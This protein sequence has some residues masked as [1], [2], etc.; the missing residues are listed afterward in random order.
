M[1]QSKRRARKSGRLSKALRADLSQ[2][3]LAAAAAGMG[4]L[5]ASNPAQAQIVFTPANQEIGP[6]QKLFIDFNHDGLTDLIISENPN[7]SGRIFSGNS[8]KALPHSGG[9]VKQGYGEG[10]A[11]ALSRG[12]RIGPGEFFLPKRA[13]IEQTYSVYYRGSWLGG[14]N[15]YL[16]VRFPIDGK[17]HYGWARLDV[18]WGISVVL[19]GYAYETQPD[20]PINAGQTG[21]EEYV[22]PSSEVSPTPRS[23]EKATVGALALGVPGIGIWRRAEP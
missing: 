11:Q 2:Y 21:A 16:G 9:G 13:I 19:S 14:G 22:E 18:T 6:N 12:A 8:V 20:I 7:R 1:A 3:A 4:I 5:A 23:A 15:Y 10:F 17:T